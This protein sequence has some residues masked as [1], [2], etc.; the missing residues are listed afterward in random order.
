MTRD[1]A[2]TA[3]QNR[4]AQLTRARRLGP[5]QAFDQLVQEDGS[6]DALREAYDALLRAVP[7][8]KSAIDRVMADRIVR[9]RAGRET[10]VRR[11]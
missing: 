7:D 4:L 9:P 1:E 3:L 11:R 10:Q 5:Y 6:T 8:M 2:I